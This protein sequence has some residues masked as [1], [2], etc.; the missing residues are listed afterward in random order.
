MSK[1]RKKNNIAEGMMT[2]SAAATK[3]DEVL[4]DLT[5][6]TYRADIKTIDEKNR[7]IEAIV[8]TEDRIRVVDWQRCEV[9]E[10]ILRMDGLEMPSNQQVPLLDTHNRFSVQ[11]QLGSTRNFKIEGGKLVARNFYSTS[12]AADHAWTL[13]REGH[14]TDNSIGYR[15]SNGVMIEPGQTAEV[16]GIQYTASETMPLRIAVGWGI[17]ENSVCPIGADPKAKTRNE[18]S[19]LKGQ[20]TFLRKVQ[21]MEFKEW[22]SARG[23]NYDELSESTRA[24]LKA[25]FDAQSQRPQEPAGKPAESG[26]SEPQVVSIGADEAKRIAE[27]AVAAD[28]ARQSMIRTEAAGLGIDDAV[29]SR[30]ISDPKMTIENARAE[31]LTAVRNRT[32]NNVINAPAGIVVDKGADAVRLADAML[33]RAGFESEVLKEKDG[34][35]RAEQASRFRDISAIELCRY[36]LTMEGRNIPFAK[37]DLI[38][39]SLSTM[40]LPAILGAVYNKSLLK[41]YNTVSET[42]RKWCN[43]GSLSD[44]KTATRCR[45]TGAG[46]FGKANSGGDLPMGSAVDEKEQYR[47][48]TYGKRDRFSRQDIINDDLSVLTRV[49]ERHGRDG[50]LLIARMVYSHLLANGN[51]D[52]GTA[53]FVAG[54]SNL[55]T[56]S[57]LTR[58]NVTAALTAFR[59]QV[60]KD[61]KAIKIRPAFLLVPVEL[62]DTA[63]EMMN[64]E[65]IIVAGT[66]DTVKGS[67]NVLQGRLE[68]VADELLSDSSITGYSTTSWYITGDPAE[69]DTVEV[70]FLNGRQEPTVNMNPKA[71][72]MYIEFEGYVDVGVKA[73]DFRSMQKNNS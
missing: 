28:H 73:L 49:A 12:P 58:S 71:S 3:P 27:E 18:N 10:E 39:A 36:A 38:R 17:R 34:A 44:F 61:K 46:A 51:M 20:K 67:K 7:S 37:D 29:V 50:K 14:L 2:R 47:L 9:I 41:G 45:L 54:H 68:V 5:T 30:C 57:A 8:A 59:K 11:S 6:R 69:C 1:L 63:L 43:I 31:F 70:G 21:N 66:T 65:L 16:G 48:D 22:L 26:R 42:W 33:L 72:D 53:L 25:D 55:R 19:P 4:C 35:K 40:T 13:C 23:L 24:A 32:S 56:S 62:E 52:D 15:V 60:D 64:S